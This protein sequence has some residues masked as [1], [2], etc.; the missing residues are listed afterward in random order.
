MMIEA[1]KVS[2]G[3]F[4]TNIFIATGPEWFLRKNEEIDLYSLQWQFSQ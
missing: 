3:Y 4:Y 2:F 1:M